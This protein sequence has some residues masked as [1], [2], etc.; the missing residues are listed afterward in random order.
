[1]EIRRDGKLMKVCTRCNLSDD[2]RVR[3]LV[4]GSDNAKL[5]FDYDPLGAMVLSFD[6]KEGGETEC[7]I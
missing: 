6:M 4:Q 1:M 7:Q 3:L 2:E 5:W